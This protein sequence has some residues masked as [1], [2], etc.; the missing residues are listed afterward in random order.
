[1]VELDPGHYRLIDD[2]ERSFPQGPPSLRG[3]KH[4]RVEGDVRFG[5]GVTVQGSVTIRNLDEGPL[6]IEDGAIL[7]G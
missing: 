1:M 3:C 5:A 6:H 4:F 2:L 7:E